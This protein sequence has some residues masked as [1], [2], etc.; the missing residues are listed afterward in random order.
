MLNS[1]LLPDQTKGHYIL[2]SFWGSSLVKSFL[3]L[4]LAAASLAA[5]DPDSGGNLTRRITA[6]SQFFDH[7]FVNFYAYA[8]G[9]W[10]SRVPTFGA[11]NVE[12]FGSGLGWEAGGGVTATHTFK[13]GGITVNYR[14]SYRDYQTAGASGGQQ[15]SLSLGYNKRLNRHWSLGADVSGAIL[16]YGDSFYSASSLASTVSGNP[17]STESRYANASVSVTYQQTRRLSYVFTGNYLLNSYKYAGAFSSHGVGGGASVL[18]RLTARTTIGANY[19]RTYFTYSQNAGSSS[20]DTGSLT[21]SHIFPQHWQIDL[22]GGVNRSHSEGTILVP[23]SLIFNGQL[24]SGY[25]IGQ[26]NRTLYSPAFQGVLTRAFRRSSISV[27]GGQSV[28]GGNGTYLTSRDQFASG[29][30]S[31]STH[32]S[33]LSLG[34]SFTRLSSVAN[35]VSQTYSYYGASAGYGLNLFRYVSANLRY[36]LIHYDGLFTFAGITESRVSFGLS[37]STKSVPLTLF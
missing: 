33:N 17:F 28:M 29:T 8:N 22:S 32:R 13:D 27:S 26:Y 5:Q 1:L 12:T 30:F 23:I 24:V 14:G 7:D 11:N 4:C 25:Q 35:N 19:S 10:D 18:Y 15:Q 3:I 16:T 31:Y 37:L 2:K 34:G 36:D 20:I 21:L 9:V 6:A